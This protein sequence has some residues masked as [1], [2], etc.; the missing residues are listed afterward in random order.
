VRKQHI[1]TL[2]ASALGFM[3]IC[4]TL[5]GAWDMFPEAS[6][7]TRRPQE[8]MPPAE[9]SAAIEAQRQASAKL[10]RSA[11]FD[12]RF[13]KLIETAQKSGT[14]PVVVKVRAAFRPEAQLSS[15]AELLAQRKVIEEAQDQMLS[16]LK[17]VPSTLKRYKYIPYI[18]TSVDTAGLEQLQSS[19]ETLD[20]SG[21]TAMRLTM[22]ESLPRVGA[23]R[24]WAG[25]FTGADKIIAVLDSGVDKNHPW[26]S[27]KVV[28]EA[29]YSTND[30]VRGYSSICPQGVTESTDPNSGIPCDIPGFGDAG[31]C[32][33]G[34]HVAGIA[35]GR[36][37]VA[38]GANIISIQVMSHVTN[39]DA[40]RGEPSCLLAK[41]SD[42]VNALN[43][44]YELRT[45]HN[46]DIAAVNISLAN[47]T[48]T[49]GVA[50]SEYCDNISAE[51]QAMAAAINQLRSVNVATIA[52]AGN[53]FRTDALNFP[54]CISSAISVGAT[55]DGGPGA[56]PADTVAEFSNSA[57][58]LNLLAPGNIIT[59]SAPGGGG[60]GVFGTSMAAAHASGAMAILRQE[61]PIGTNSTVWFD[62][63]M[64]E[65][66]VPWPDN[67]ATGGVDE[68]WNWVSA[69]PTP[70]SGIASHQ[71]S[72]VAATNIRQHYFMN[73]T[74]TLQIGTG[75]IL[76]A[77]VYVDPVEKPSQIMLQWND[78]TSWEHRA[79]WGEN[80][81][82]W[83]VDGTPSRI[84]MGTLPQDGG[85]VKLVIP[86]RAVGLEGGIVSGMAFTQRGGRVTWDQTGKESASVDDLLA[87]LKSTG[88]PVKDTRPGA[89]DRIV[90][91]IK[92]DAAL[93]VSVPE[94]AWVGEYYN[95]R[96]L[97]NAPVVVRNDGGGFIDRNFNGASPAPGIGAT[98]YSI[99]WTRTVTLTEGDYRFSLTGDDGMK[100][101]ID[102]EEKID[103]WSHPAGNSYN[104]DEHL[105]SGN[106]EIRLEYNQITGPAYVR[107]IWGPFNPACSQT[108]AGDHWKGEY[109]NNPN[110]LGET[111]MV[112]DDDM[113]LAQD[114]G[115]GSPSQTCSVFPDNFSARW[116]RKAG[117]LATRYRFTVNNVDDG[118]R[119]YVG[120]QLRMD[121]WFT[122]SGTNMVEVDIPFA[123]EHQIVLEFFE[124]GGLARAN[125]SWTLVPPSAP[126]NLVAGATS[127]SQINLNWNDNSNTED[128]FRIERWNG[129]WMHVAAVGPDVRSYADSGL[130]PSTTYLYRVKAFNN[131]G[132]S[133]YSNESSATTLSCSYGVSPPGAEFMVGGSGSITV[134][135]DAGCAWSASTNEYWIQINSGHNG[136]GNG[137]VTYTVITDLPVDS[138]RMGI[139]TVAGQP[140]YISQYTPCSTC[141]SEQPQPTALDRL[142]TDAGLRGLTASYFSNTTLS[143]Q[144][145]LQRTDAIVNFAWAGARPDAALPA[146]RFSV[147]WRGQLTAPSS[148]AYTFYLYRN[149]GARLWVNNR[150]VIDRWGP[151][152][153]TLPRSAPVEM[154]AGEKV[155]VRLEYYDA[156]GDASIHLLWSSA[157]T[158][159]QIIPQPNLYPEAATNDST[160]TDTNKQTGMLLLPGS[161]AGLK[162]TRPHCLLVARTD[163]QRQPVPLA[164]AYLT[165][166]TAV[167]IAHTVCLGARPGARPRQDLA[168]ALKNKIT[169]VIC[170][171]DV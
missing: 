107:L 146:D 164:A 147:R 28:S 68:S 97:A 167:A 3:A 106:H 53:E 34:T 151:P 80:K 102:G 69:N 19:F 104:V 77:W 45:V 63:A 24:A 111:V 72:I 18:A 81:I 123:G 116:T 101:Y 47:L 168:E 35:A 61:L 65:G 138:Y 91:R 121:R 135:A 12:Q 132:D 126:S 44:V 142:A 62:D 136:S 21:D 78:G 22:S 129:G 6:S 171:F 153:E 96:D 27:G 170:N 86:A 43:Y 87:L 41:S 59:F 67:T 140:V 89:N 131:G 42:V 169:K 16:W 109:F 88:A 127:R 113:N 120:G 141:I 66:A 118:V 130:A 2:T 48:E 36:S 158:P 56:T 156:E 23:M 10:T 162:A 98:D 38:Y 165:M 75:E 60:A 161:D 124:G 145:A 154:K 157:S 32:G 57:P 114:W 112:R 55:N 103:K 83:G 20:V 29:C 144:P 1:R 14:V 5:S 7:Q 92:V 51:T 9:V 149:G 15:A 163:R 90:P 105:S 64:P 150:L 122:S 110:L 143:G 17:Y 108:V 148:E 159:K 115:S 71:S 139:L 119:L 84:N 50:F 13:R 117:F 100:L 11:S 26:L 70:H 95:N 25:G 82:E 74:S 49:E 52:A 39:F 76:Y 33:H 128:G 94:Q 8:Q 155:D 85:W 166:W 93:G 125:V 134:S 46:Y 4:I 152:F 54:A 133:G 30:D 58:F 37:G 137:T 40:C 79:Y 99:R 73:A 160:P 31:R